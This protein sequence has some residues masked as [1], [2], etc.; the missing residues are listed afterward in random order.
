MNIFVLIKQV[1]DTEAVLAVRDGKTIN[2]DGIKWIISPYDEYAIEEAIKLKEQNEGYKVNILTLGPQRSE[3]AIRSALA[4]GADNGIH[5][6]T[7]EHPNAKET[8]KILAEAIK[9]EP[10]HG[11]IFM[12]KQAIDEDSN[13][14][15][16]LVAEFLGLPV[17]TNVTRFTMNG[18][19]VVVDREIDEGAIETIEMGIPCVI[20]ASKGLNTPRYASLMGIMKAKK[21]PLKKISLSDLGFAELSGSVSTEKLYSPPE[22]PEGKVLE[23]EPE[24]V[25]KELV[26][27][28]K[29]EVKVL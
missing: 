22:K 29:E 3:S 2:E 24:E 7:D 19:K 1:P 6:E 10:D 8:A 23:G 9:K 14:I 27:L 21:I 4:M 15:H 16:I 20:G 25:V 17:A 26:R 11:I 18:D 28:L 12:G 13:Q 5:I